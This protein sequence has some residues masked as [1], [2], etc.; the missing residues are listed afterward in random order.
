LPALDGE[1]FLESPTDTVR[2]LVE[3][4]H[5]CA[6]S[7]VVVAAS[8]DLE[9]LI[10]GARAIGWMGAANSPILTDIPHRGQIPRAP[11]AGGMMGQ[12]AGSLAISGKSGAVTP[13]GRYTNVVDSE[14]EQL[15]RLVSED[16]RTGA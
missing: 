10:G 5:P 16:L 13:R 7:E 4:L 12:R 3:A 15:A 1:A 14:L 9:R 2:A 11:S 8:A 6:G